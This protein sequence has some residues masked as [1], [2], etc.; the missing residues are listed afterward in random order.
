[1]TFI[2]SDYFLNKMG[3]VKLVFVGDGAVGCTCLIIRYLYNK[4]MNEY[5]PTVFDKYQKCVEID[6]KE[7]TLNVIDTA[8]QEEYGRLRPLHYPATD[9]F[10]VVF[11]VVRPASYEN[12][13]AK[14]IP[15][16]KHHMPNTSIVLVGNQI[17]KRTDPNC[18]KQLAESKKKEEPITTEMGVK[19]AREIN[20]ATYVECSCL[21]QRGVK[22]LFEKSIKISQ[23]VPVE[24]HDKTPSLYI[25]MMGD[26][27]V[28]KTALT[29]AYLVKRFDDQSQ[30]SRYEYCSARS[31]IDDEQYITHIWSDEV[32]NVILWSVIIL[33]FSV[34]DFQSYNNISTKWIP[35]VKQQ[36]PTVPVIL[37]GNKTDL[38]GNNSKTVTTEMGMQLAREINAV[39]YFECSCRDGRT[40]AI[41]RIFETAAR[42]SYFVKVEKF[43][44]KSNKT[45]LK[46]YVV[47][48]SNVGKSSLQNRFQT[49][50]R[51]NKFNQRLN[52]F[53]QSFIER[54]HTDYKFAGFT[55]MDGEE[56]G[57]IICNGLSD[58]KIARR[59]DKHLLKKDRGIDVLMLMYSVDDFDSYLSVENFWIPELLKLKHYKPKI[60]IVLVGSKTDLRSVAF[61]SIPTE[62]GEQLAR[63]INAAKY[64]ECSTCNDEEVE[65]VFEETAWAS[66]RY[67]AERRKPKS[68]FKRFFGQ[69]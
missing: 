44:K 9:V 7:Y 38:R 32:P 17:D 48:D 36:C 51:L 28:G 4:F 41:E 14:W 26:S 69:K 58:W 64:L 10:V 43:L 50:K 27:D 37:V 22:N 66:I 33:V 63:R 42:A 11:S 29:D 21:D 25:L 23:N 67:A 6:G 19:L 5:A 8:G 30:P 18:L 3:E 60:P 61:Q 20:A 56:C 1:M 31:S 59:G 47:G 57:W 2:H 34:H 45:L 12:V 52:V 62:M 15:E 39:A 68:W 49:N 46:V 54:W 53:D 13:A 35:Q 40:A 16:V 24:F 55:E 65:R